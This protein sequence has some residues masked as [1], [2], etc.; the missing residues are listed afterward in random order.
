[1]ERNSTMKVP[2]DGGVVQ[3]PE[4]ELDFDNDTLR[5]IAEVYKNEGNAEYQKRE[6]TNAIHFYTK[7]IKVNCRDDE[8]NSKLYSNRAT[9]HFYLGNYRESLNDAKAAI[10]LHPHYIKAIARGACACFELGLYEEAIIWCDKGLAI[11]KNHQRLLE[12]KMRSMD[13]QEKGKSQSTRQTLKERE[14]VD[15]Q[16]N[17][18]VPK[19]HFY[20]GSL[21][22]AKETGDRSKEANACKRVIITWVVQNNKNV[23]TREKKVEDMNNVDDVIDSV[24]KL[25][26][27]TF[28]VIGVRGGVRCEDRSLEGTR[29]PTPDL[30]QGS[31][32][33][34]ISVSSQKHQLRRL[35]DVIINPIADLI[36]GD[37]LIIVPEGPLWLAPYA[38]FIDSNSRFL[39]ESFKIRV[40]PSLTALKMII[41]RPGDLVKPSALLVGD[42]WVQEVILPDGTRLCELPSAKEEVDMIG[43]ILDVMPLTGKDASKYEVLK[44]L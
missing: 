1:M 39:F 6:F 44:R 8:L 17:T 21:K 3:F 9:C 42:P 34:T 11:S 26:D 28:D 23:H 16:L 20:E 31:S 30:A 13:I 43:K 2:E 29:R 37:E 4:R 32:F 27:S 36:H 15:P 12:I 10:E 18:E 5:A 14:N 35:Y 7:G 19:I 38:A 40:I 24:K 33:D 22:K 25:I 41:D